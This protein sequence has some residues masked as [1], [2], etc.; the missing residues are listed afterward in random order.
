MYVCLYLCVMARLCASVAVC[1][2]GCVTVYLCV[3]A[4]V[5]AQSGL[6]LTGV[7]LSAGCASQRRC[8]WRLRGQQA[9]RR[10]AVLQAFLEAKMSNHVMDA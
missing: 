1:L 7:S 5:E 9:A 2:C 3:Y 8:R 10:T 4:S 6:R